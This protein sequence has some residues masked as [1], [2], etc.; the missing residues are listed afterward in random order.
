MKNKI[1]HTVR[2]VKKNNRK[3]VE[4]GKNRY[5]PGTGTL[6]KKIKKCGGVKLAL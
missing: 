5:T 1:Q 3:I 4:M 2:T 6:I